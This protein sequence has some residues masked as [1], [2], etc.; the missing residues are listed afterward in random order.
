MRHSSA[1][2]SPFQL[3]YIDVPRCTLLLLLVRDV[4]R[5]EL[6]K[7]LHGFLFKRGVPEAENIEQLTRLQAF[8]HCAE[9]TVMSGVSNAFIAGVISSN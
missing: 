5:E 8:D 7:E 6:G 2:S 9:I 3:E 1:P 4:V